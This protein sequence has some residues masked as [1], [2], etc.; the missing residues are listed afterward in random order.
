MPEKRRKFDKEFCEVA[1]RIVG[2]SSKP[3]AQVALDMA[4]T[5]AHWATG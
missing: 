1:V 4:S 5:R 2:E 3:I